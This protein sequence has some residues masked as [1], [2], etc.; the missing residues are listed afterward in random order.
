MTQKHN[1][2]QK[3]LCPKLFEQEIHGPKCKFQS[4][5][6]HICAKLLLCLYH[7]VDLHDKKHFLLDIRKNLRPFTQGCFVPSLVEID[8]VILEKNVCKN[9]SMYC[10]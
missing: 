4:I 1:S 6:K 2:L 3:K 9:L 5:I 7:N 8:F 10:T